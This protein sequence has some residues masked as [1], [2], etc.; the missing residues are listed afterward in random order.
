[1]SSEGAIDEVLEYMT[2]VGFAREEARF[3]AMSEKL[4]PSDW[5]LCTA[6]EAIRQELIEPLLAELRGSPSDDFERVIRKWA[7][8][9]TAFAYLKSLPVAARQHISDVEWVRAFFMAQ[10][11]GA[12][13]VDR[14]PS[15]DSSDEFTTGEGHHIVAMSAHG[16]NREPYLVQSGVCARFQAS[17]QACIGDPPEGWF[18]LFHATNACDLLSV[19]SGPRHNT[20]SAFNDFGPA[21]YVTTR[22][23]QALA[24]ARTKSTPHSP[25]AVAIWYVPRSALRE[26]STKFFEYNSRFKNTVKKF[27][28]LKGRERADFME[29]WDGAEADLV[30]GPVSRLKLGHTWQTATFADIFSLN[31]LPIGGSAPDYSNQYAFRTAKAMRTVFKAEGVRACGIVL[32]EP[33]GKKTDDEHTD[34]SFSDDDE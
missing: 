33:V 4:G 25:G 3:K 17:A 1:M 30:T 14:L 6:K 21:F 29:S 19:L 16:A 9:S 22:V 28:L 8:T 20:G 26:L 34:E 2:R 7:P 27:R 11:K 15:K 23:K 18:A 12:L 5:G 13:P 31:L 32:Q 24:W 10:F